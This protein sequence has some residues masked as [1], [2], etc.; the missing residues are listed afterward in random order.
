MQAYGLFSFVPSRG[1]KPDKHGIYGMAKLRGN[2]NT[3]EEADERAETIVRD[4]DSYHKVYCTYVGRPF[5]CTVNSKYSAETSEIDIK[6]DTTNVIS[7]DIK[8][9]KS[10][11]KK[12]IREI[13]KRTEEL[14][15]DT[16]KEDD[17]YDTYITLQVKRAQLTW[18]YN[19]HKNKM[20][21][22]K[23]IIIKTRKEITAL[24]EE[25]ES[26][27]TTFYDKYMEARKKSGLPETDE[28]FVKYLCADIKL[29]FDN[30]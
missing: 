29:D 24:D 26:Y 17:P 20:E 12:E 10:G 14:Y 28:S 15:E 19:E 13:E 6:K 21:E 4:V 11:D 7:Q 3:K 25:Y 8:A 2:F 18:T 30:E 9:Q 16:S 5:P 23:N 27:K 22:I 1:A